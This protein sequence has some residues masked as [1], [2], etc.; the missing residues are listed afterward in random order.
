MDIGNV[1]GRFDE[2]NKEIGKGDIFS[3]L[4]KVATAPLAKFD[5][6]DKKEEEKP[7]PQII[8]II[9]NNAK[10]EEDQQNKSQY[11][12]GASASASASA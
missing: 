9:I 5:K 3:G 12:G 11:V 4:G 6:G 8:N 2:G 10:G 7:A 1:L